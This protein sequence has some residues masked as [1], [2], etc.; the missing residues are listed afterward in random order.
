[1]ARISTYDEISVVVELLFICYF[2][3]YFMLVLVTSGHG[4]F[5]KL[6]EACRTHFHL[7]APPKTAVMPDY[8]NNKK[9]K[10]FTTNQ[11]NGSFNALAKNPGNVR[12]ISG[13]FPGHFHIV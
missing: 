11:N 4:R 13:T 5:Q 9:T 1:M 2:L 12:D 10:T 8:D 7:V 6:P 3:V